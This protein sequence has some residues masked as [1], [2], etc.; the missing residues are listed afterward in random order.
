MYL[1]DLY[2]TWSKQLTRRMLSALGEGNS[3]AT[4]ALAHIRTVKAF[5][6]EPLEKGMYEETAKEALR[7]GIKDSLGF[8]LTSALTGYLDL[9]AG[10]LILWY[11][12]ILVLDDQ[13]NMTSKVTPNTTHP[14]TTHPNTTLAQQSESSSL[15]SSTGT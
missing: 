3:I 15:F 7:L 14:N 13:G 6:S 9:G 11:G 1:W 10:V 12:G 2:G 5:A 8:G 4:E